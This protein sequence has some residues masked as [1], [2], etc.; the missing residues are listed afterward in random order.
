MTLRFG[1]KQFCYCK[2][3]IRAA[4]AV[5]Q[6]SSERKT[7]IVEKEKER[8]HSIEKTLI[9]IERT[10]HACDRRTCAVHVTT[11]GHNNNDTPFAKYRINLFT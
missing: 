2:P 10:A 1:L 6:T 11:V 9:L 7:H 4:T 5:R 3:G 8:R